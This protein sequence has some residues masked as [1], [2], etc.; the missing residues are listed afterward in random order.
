MRKQGNCLTNVGQFWKFRLRRG[1][2]IPVTRS[3]PKI[4][5]KLW[6]IFLLFQRHGSKKARM[7][8]VAYIQL[9]TW[10][11]SVRELGC[12]SR[13]IDKF[14]VNTC[15]GMGILSETWATCWGGCEGGRKE[16]SETIQQGGQRSNKKYW[17]ILIKQLSEERAESK[18]QDGTASTLGSLDSP[19][20]RHPRIGKAAFFAC[21]KFLEISFS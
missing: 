19:H 8:E 13:V 11:R 15:P 12:S 18:I 16:A 5:E 17:K 20:L 4:S 21:Q 10:E 3:G 14:C 1:K 6:I 9:Y 7:A 2:Q